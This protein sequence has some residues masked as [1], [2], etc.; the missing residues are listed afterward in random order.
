ME[1]AEIFCALGNLEPVVK[2]WAAL[3]SSPDTFLKP[4]NQKSKTTFLLFTITITIVIM[5][6]QVPPG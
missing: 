3:A 1:T 6:V 5:I 4:E 2:Y